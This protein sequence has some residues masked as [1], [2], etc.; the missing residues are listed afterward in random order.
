MSHVGNSY[1][2]IHRLKISKVH[3]KHRLFHPYTPICIY[4]HTTA[5]AEGNFLLALALLCF[6]FLV[7]RQRRSRSTCSHPVVVVVLV[8]VPRPFLSYV[9]SVC[10]RVCVYTYTLYTNVMKGGEA[11][12]R[13]FQKGLLVFRRVSSDYQSYLGFLLFGLGDEWLERLSL[14]AWNFGRRLRS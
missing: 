6:L 8:V 3:N 2:S 13:R 10:A 11:I 1:I 5:S 9:S 4:L 14:S 7:E 12:L